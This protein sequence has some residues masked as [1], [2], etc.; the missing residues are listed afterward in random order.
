[1]NSR[2]FAWI[3]SMTA[4][5][6]AVA[7]GSSDEEDRQKVR[8]VP[9]KPG[10]NQVNLNN[11]FPEATLRDS[12]NLDLAL[13]V[14]GAVVEL[15]PV[16]EGA[17][18]YRATVSFLIRQNSTEAG[19]TPKVF[20]IQAEGEVQTGAAEA[21][22]LAQKQG[23][24]AQEIHMKSVL[25]INPATSSADAD[26]LY[27][28]QALCLSDCKRMVVRIFE[29]EKSSGGEETVRQT[30]ILFSAVRSQKESQDH[31]LVLLINRYI[32]GPR[33]ENSVWIDDATLGKLKKTSFLKALAEREKNGTL[34]EIVPVPADAAADSSANATDNAGEEP[35]EETPED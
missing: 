1:M 15:V 13:R 17:P 22:Q 35:V 33:G 10:A 21:L 24:N 28:V 4:I 29:N 23:D 20:Q 9:V 18:S 7:C 31:S 8:V 11:I 32:I 25:T 27:G 26:K 3:L 14:E 5:S 2:F 6:F 12:K 19:G 30:A 16:D 34:D